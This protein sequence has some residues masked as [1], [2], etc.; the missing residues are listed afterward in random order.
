M[1]PARG[2]EGRQEEE[3]TTRMRYRPLLFSLVDLQLVDLDVSGSGGRGSEAAS[4]RLHDEDWPRPLYAQAPPRRGPRRPRRD[5][6]SSGSDFA[7]PP[8]LTATLAC[9]PSM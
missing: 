7:R 2:G 1:A 4:L 5:R 9:L 3:D 8:V 6:A